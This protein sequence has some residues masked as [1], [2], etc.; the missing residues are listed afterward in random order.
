MSRDLARVKQLVKERCGLLL[1]GNG[2]ANLVQVLAERARALAIDPTQYFARLRDSGPEFQELVNRLTV[3]E[4]YFFREAE[5]IRLLVDRLVPRLL[6]AR[7]GLAPVRILSAGCSSGEE[8]YS[9]VMALMDKYGQS[10][11]RL[12]EFAGGDIDSAA[13][14]KARNARYSRFS[15]RGVPDDV[16][17]RYFDQDRWGHVL[18]APVRN[19]V[20]F[21]EFNLL[22]SSFSSTLRDFDVIFFRN[23][24]IYFDAPTR[25]RV[26]Q[27]LVSL[28]KDDGVLL[29]GSAET[30]ANDLG[31]LPLV[32]E[33]GLF[34]FAK[35]RPP[36]SAGATHASLSVGRTVPP[37]VPAVSLLPVP[38]SGWC[39][40]PA[41]MPALAASQ[42]PRPPSTPLADFDT[43]RQLMRDK[44]YDQALPLLEAVLA[45][46]P[47][48]TEALLLKA[49]VLI[50]RSDFVGTERLAQGVLAAHA[51]SIDAL[52][53]L[54][55][56]AKWQQQSEAAIRWFKQAAYA[57]HECWPAH[58]YLADLYRDRGENAL[59]RRAYRVVIQLLCGNEPDTGIQYVSLGLPTGDIRFLCEHQLARL[60]IAKALA[61]Q[62]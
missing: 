18:K 29:F 50:N 53:L 26:Q 48:N 54:G 45:I 10:V 36:L 12:F 60:P 40:S 22:A 55:L 1:E 30:L 20:T 61:G 46:E 31:V 4:T 2:E 21:H 15:F 8:P 49:H 9:L 62:G 16:R 11:S 57:R 35:G 3:N 24:S 5:Q 14:A 56:A 6:A 19:Q 42:S 13:L 51:W 43:L 41:A 27:N 39:L 23:V 37:P 34:Y 52:M 17:A 44:Y 58:Y 47:D 28:M 32:E 33:G 25:K 59:A 7:A 38:S